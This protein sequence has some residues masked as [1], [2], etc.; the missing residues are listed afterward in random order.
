MH[1][2]T[3]MDG[4][5]LALAAVAIEEFA[6][7]DELVRSEGLILTRPAGGKYKHPA[8][9]VRAD[10]WRRVQ[11]GLRSFGLDPVARAS[12][13]AIEPDESDAVAARYFSDPA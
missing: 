6:A 10:A 3:A 2:T 4:D 5:S 7:A 11:S 13:T 1:I 9:A 8:V 12:V